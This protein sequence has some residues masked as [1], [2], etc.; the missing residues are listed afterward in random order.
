[1][2]ASELGSRR[3]S[4]A[5]YALR[6]T[7]AAALIHLGGSPTVEINRIHIFV[8]PRLRRNRKKKGTG[9]R[10]RSLFSRPVSFGRTT[11]STSASGNDLDGRSSRSRLW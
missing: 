2:G 7:W 3:P 5:A 10:L 6:D 1:M 11:M 8:P 9:G 4:H